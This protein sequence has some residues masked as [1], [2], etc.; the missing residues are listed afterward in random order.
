MATGIGTLERLAQAEM[1]GELA[2]LLDSLAEATVRGAPK[3]APRL[4]RTLVRAIVCRAYSGLI[5]ELVH[6]MAAAHGVNRARGYEQMFW[7]QGPATAARFRAAFE[8]ALAHAPDAA[9]VAATGNGIQAVYGDGSFAVAFSRMPLLAAMLDFLVSAL[10]YREVDEAVRS[11]VK[12]PAS[13]AALKRAANR[14]TRALYAFLKPR[15]PAAQAQRKYR[16]LMSFLSDR[17]GD[18]P[19]GKDAIDDDAVFEFWRDHG[20]DA[21]GDWKTYRTAVK[22]FLHLRDALGAAA[23]RE[24]MAGALP[25]DPARDGE[26][27]A[28]DLVL[29]AC[30]AVDRRAEAI[31]CLR[32]PPAAAV[33]FLTKR[34]AEGIALIL[35]AGP[36]AR[37]LRL[38]VLRAAIFGAMQAS[39][40]QTLRQG[41]QGV[42]AVNDACARGGDSYETHF[43]ALAGLRD[44]LE[45]VLAA[46]YHV[47]AQARDGQAISILLAL[48]PGLDLRP[49][50]ANLAGPQPAGLNVVA[51]GA[52]A[53]ARELFAHA[54][55]GAPDCPD[56]ER[57]ASR[58]AAA[59][60]GL[61][62]KGFGA[63]EAGDPEIIAGFSAGAP[64]LLQIRDCLGRFIAAIEALM[65]LARDRERRMLADRILFLNQFRILYGGTP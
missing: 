30:A 26:A 5:Y 31:D 18:A 55:D 45:R 41:K 27:E 33:K 46:A 47:L 25:L 56:L 6:L 4:H 11:A 44:H 15:L 36:H 16:A 42:A 10:G 22:A 43:A 40:S 59:H 35:G 19:V 54:A 51:I 38:S 39:I 57:F 32:A 20:T 52:E 48:D 12:P 17:A 21:Q 62:R 34:E 37:A 50:A 49:L 2:E 9:N 7:D 14:I 29:A 61:S 13:Q 8:R 24:A 63:N 64:A 3:Y 1:G 28:S 53:A 58:A 23:D 65:P 60:R